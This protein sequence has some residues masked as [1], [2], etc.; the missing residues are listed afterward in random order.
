MKIRALAGALGVVAVLAVAG[1]GPEDDASVTP[2][3][4][5]VMSAE[6]S[7]STPAETVEPEPT[8]MA[9]DCPTWDDGFVE[10]GSEIAA[11]NFNRFA[12]VCVGM[13]YDEAASRWPDAFEGN[14]SCPWVV[15]I[16]TGDDL[17]IGAISEYESPGD[18]IRFFLARLWADPATFDAEELFAN[19]EGIRLG[20]TEGDVLAAYPDATFETYGDDAGMDHES[21]LVAGPEGLNY[22]FDIYD[23]YVTAIAWGDITVIPG[24][25][26]AL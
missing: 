25:I 4:S 15:D 16:A 19:E 11:Y 9:L 13:S 22:V 18:D 2:S 14:P 23:G 17:Y 6:P 24:H 10:P 26:C 20:S 7:P 8:A 3:P 21:W 1:C 12:G 5:P